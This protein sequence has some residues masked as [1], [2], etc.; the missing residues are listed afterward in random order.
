MP[1]QKLFARLRSWLF[2][3]TH[4][5]RLERDMDEE[6]RFHIDTYAADLMREGLPREEAMRRA[7][8]EFGGI[9]GRKEDC[10]EARGLR[11]VDE[12]RADV[13]YTLRQLRRAPVFTAV[14][15]LSLGLSIGANTAIFSMMEQAL[16]KSMPVKDADRL[17]V[18]TWE[19]LPPRNVMSSEWGNWS[20]SFQTASGGNT[21]EAFSFEVFQALRERAS[22]FEHVFAYK[23][24]GRVTVV[25]DGQAEVINAH[26]VSGNFYDGLGVVPIAGRAI[27]PSDDR[28]DTGEIVGVI[29]DGYW[30]R[31]FG[32]DPSIIGRPIDVNQL[33]VTI[34]G[35]NPPAFTG[36]ES[37]GRPDIFIPVIAQPKLRP[38]GQSKDGS[39]LNDPDY[40]WL[41]VMGRLK[42]DASD[43]QAEREAEAILQQVSRA[44]R[45]AHPDRK[46]ASLPLLHL[47]AGSRGLDNLRESFGRPL[48]ILLAFVAVVLLIA[49]TNVAN[50]LL[51]RA[52]ARRRELSLRLALGAA[53]PRI[54]RQLLTEGLTL[55]IGGGLLG[56]LIGYWSRDA[57]PA[58]MLRSWE[59]DRLTAVFDTRVLLLAIAVTI[60]T[61]VLFSLAPIWQSMR[62]D[63][64]TALKDSGRTAARGAAPL[65][66]RAL[67]VFQIA[68]SVLILIAA[69]L[70]AR[71]LANINSVAL[72]FTPDRVLL[73]TLDPPRAR[74]HG[75]ARTAL[76][77]RI[78]AQIA[79][80]PG[81]EDA[82]LSDQPL[83]SGGRS[84]SSITLDGKA[85][86]RDVAPWIN[87]VGHRFTETM[88]IP[89]LSGRSFDSR[90]RQGSLPVVLVNRRFVQQYLSDDPNPLGRT[91]RNG[92]I[93]WQ[94]IG[95]CGDAHY[96]TARNEVPPTFY[97]L[98]VQVGDAGPMIFAVRTSVDTAAIL[99]SVRQTI[100]TVDKDL[101]IFDVHTQVQQINSTISNERLFAAL[102]VTFGLLALVLASIGIYGLL[103]HNVSRRTGEI[104]IRIAL[105]ANRL[106]VLLMVLREASVLATIGVAAGVLVAVWLGRYIEAMLFGVQF[107]DP[108]TIGGA[109]ALMMFVAVLAGWLPARRASR[110]DPMVALR[111]D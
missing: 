88:G 68:M 107:H 36:V 79:A 48:L 82:S 25:V 3:V 7:Y 69:C 66:G 96:D 59:R 1:V 35:V 14:A 111:H 61:S 52:A 21:S 63:L 110:L 46:D 27:L 83:I 10:R 4:R 100:A 72:G 6:L 33:P 34:V 99:N 90:D 40:W 32:R 58:L 50:L 101:P 71:T 29:S 16:W 5:S 91:F 93:T 108:F 12:A 31:R 102:T 2:G 73:F 45:D 26:L 28:A 89:I 85:K 54:A 60:A 57:I 9:E 62:V 17:R 15:I 104:G 65:R 67:I 24:I 51:A 95:I 20:R 19:T 11:L 30:A 56:V 109:I 81:V 78:R 80:I 42:A 64:N 22:A 23:S 18:F 105:G 41:G 53:R 44:L 47:L 86:V 97:P 49:C 84:R 74:Y 13:R 55:G 106:D 75:T 103:A 98:F 87:S 94:I 92:K 39:L 70:F 8:A 38:R 37:D 43:T 77:D 76:F